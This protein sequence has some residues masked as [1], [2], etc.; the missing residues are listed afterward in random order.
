VI[1]FFKKVVRIYR[2]FCK[3]EGSD[4]RI[5]DVKIEFLTQG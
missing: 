3:S 1:T 2:Q 5:P 4:G